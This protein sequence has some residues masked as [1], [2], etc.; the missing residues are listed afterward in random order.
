[1]W[2]G[3]RG[4]LNLRS[5]RMAVDRTHTLGSRNKGFV[6]AED[7]L[8]PPI[9][10]GFTRGGAYYMWRRDAAEEFGFRG[11]DEGALEHAFCG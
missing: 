3:I 1:M 9:S 4:I 8:I 10:S 5:E 11:D 2:K 7:E 6:S